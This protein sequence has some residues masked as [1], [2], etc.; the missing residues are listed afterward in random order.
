MAY[1]RHAFAAFAR[2]A[3]IE[4]RD[5]AAGGA[6]RSAVVTLAQPFVDDGAGGISL[7]GCDRVAGEN[8]EE[9]YIWAGPGRAS[10]WGGGQKLI[11]DLELFQ[12]EYN[13]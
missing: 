4:E 3:A 5:L 12:S 13:S 9:G 11:V 8:C 2:S 1:S 10:S 6:S 7:S